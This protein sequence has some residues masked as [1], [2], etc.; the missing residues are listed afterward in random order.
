VLF[1]N[2]PTVLQKFKF[3]KHAAGSVN[4]LIKLAWKKKGSFE[5]ANK[6]ISIIM[7]ERYKY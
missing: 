2:L 5:F 3:L 7:F 4:A 1:I 6:I